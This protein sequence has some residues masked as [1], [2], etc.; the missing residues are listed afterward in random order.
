LI[1]LVFSCQLLNYPSLVVVVVVVVVV[2]G[3]LLLVVVLLVVG[4]EKVLSG[5]VAVVVVE[6]LAV[7]MPGV[8]WLVWTWLWCSGWTRGMSGV[9]V[10]ICDELVVVVGVDVVWAAWLERHGS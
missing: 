5:W 8:E 7:A 4:L 10:R 3:G 2:G 9:A 6:G 1:Q